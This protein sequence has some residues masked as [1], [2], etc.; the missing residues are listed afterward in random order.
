MW[1]LKPRR[2]ERRGFC[3]PNGF[4]AYGACASFDLGFPGL[5]GLLLSAGGAKECN[6]ARERWVYIRRKA[7]S[8]AGA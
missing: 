6:P 4:R 7:I 8:P 3:E 2:G 5:K 1:R